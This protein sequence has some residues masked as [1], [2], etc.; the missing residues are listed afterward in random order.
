M[1]QS[2]AQRLK[3][4]VQFDKK[5]RVVAKKIN[6]TPQSISKTIVED[7]MLRSDTLEAIAEAYPQLNMRWFLTGAG[8]SGLDIEMPVVEPEDPEKELLKEELLGMYKDKA[9]MLEEKVRRME[10]D[11]KEHCGDLAKRMGI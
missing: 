6:L 2:I 9:G 1:K 5:Q 3:L 4:L 10:Q 7:R 8:E 11:I